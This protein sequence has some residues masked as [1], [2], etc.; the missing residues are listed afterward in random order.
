MH[1]GFDDD[2]SKKSSRPHEHQYKHTAKRKK[3]ERESK[4]IKHLKTQRDKP[5][6]KQTICRVKSLTF[7]IKALFC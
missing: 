7:K 6:Q 4:H 2:N 1:D 3:R 5:K